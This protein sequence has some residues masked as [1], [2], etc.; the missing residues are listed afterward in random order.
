VIGW[1]LKR[2][3]Q[4]IFSREGEEGVRS[5]GF[6]EGGVYKQEVQKREGMYSRRESSYGEDHR[7]C[8]H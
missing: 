6:Q 7:R 3:F 1:G 4:E 8:R 5:R 2:R